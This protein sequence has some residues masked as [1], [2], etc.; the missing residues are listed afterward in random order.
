GERA[1]GFPGAGRVLGQLDGTVPLTR[2]RVG[3]VALERVPVR[4]HTPLQSPEGQAVGEVTSGLLAPAID[5]PI[6][7]GYLPPEYATAGLRVQ[8]LVRGKPVP[9]ETSAMP[10]VPNRYHRG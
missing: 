7:M 9:M 2:K 3:L 6:A 10:F 1:G 4:E 8:A 5:K